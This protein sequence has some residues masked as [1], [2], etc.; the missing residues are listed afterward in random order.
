MIGGSDVVFPAVGNSASLEA[1]ARIVA[2]QWPNVRF[3]DAILG[4]KY[5][6]L[7]DIPFGHV[8]EL[9]AY[10]DAAAESAWD[11]DRL[12]TP[13]N[14]LLNLIVRPDDI[15]VVVDNPKARE[16]HSL[17]QAIHDLLWDVMNTY[18]RAA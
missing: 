12:D 2:R 11:N 6:R 18:Q 7:A 10:R 4:V 9:L 13:E 5:Q 1:C 8:K 16:M 3:E 15:T 17:L 14:V